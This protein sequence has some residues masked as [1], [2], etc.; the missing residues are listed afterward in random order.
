MFSQGNVEDLRETNLLS[1]LEPVIM[2]FLSAFNSAIMSDLQMVIK[3]TSPSS[4]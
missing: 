2:C 3:K 1:A 4:C